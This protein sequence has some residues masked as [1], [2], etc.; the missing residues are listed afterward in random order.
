MKGRI[1]ERNR[2]FVAF[3]MALLMIVSVIDLPV[4]SLK[5]EAAGEKV[6]LRGD[7]SKGGEGNHVEFKLVENPGED[8]YTIE[9]F[10]EG[11]PYDMYFSCNG[12]NAPY[13]PYQGKISKVVIHDGVTRVSENMFEYMGITE[14]TI[15]KDVTEIGAFAFYGNILTKINIP[16]NNS[17]KY[18]GEDAFGGSYDDNSKFPIKDLPR[19][20]ILAEISAFPYIDYMDFPKYEKA[21][22][23]DWEY[24]EGGFKIA[25][26]ILWDVNIGECGLNGDTMNIPEGVTNI[27]NLAPSDAGNIKK[28]HFP[29][30]TKKI[31]SEAFGNFNGLEEMT[32]DPEADIIDVGV[33]VFDETDLWDYTGTEDFMLGNVLLK[34]NMDHANTD[35]ITIASN[36]RTVASNA[37]F[38]GH[39]SVDFNNVQNVSSWLC[40]YDISGEWQFES[41]NM[42][43]VKYI[44][45][46]AF[47][48][49]KKLTSV[50]LSEKLERIS[51]AAFKNNSALE[52][53]TIPDSVKYIETYAFNNCGLKTVGI[54]S[55]S[56]L[57]YI[58]EGAFADNDALEEI[59]LPKSL[60]TLMSSAF[61][62][63][64]LK[65]INIE[66]TENLNCI[67]DDIF[68]D[69]VFADNNTKNGVLYLGDVAI[70]D[71]NT[72][73]GNI[74]IKEGTRVVVA[75]NRR[76]ADK[77]FGINFGQKELTFPTS[78]EYIFGNIV[79]VYYATC[80]E[81]I[82]LPCSLKSFSTSIN[83]DINSDSEIEIV[84]TDEVAEM[85]KFD[86]NI[87]RSSQVAT[88]TYK[89]P[90][91]AWNDDFTK[92]SVKKV[93]AACNRELEYPC[94]LTSKLKSKA[95][96]TSDGVTTVTATCKEFNISESKDV[97]GLKKI[98]TVSVSKDKVA[99]TGKNLKPS[100]VVCDTD[101]KAISSANYDVKYKNNK[102][103]G[104][105][106]A[107]VTFKGDYE[108]SK[109]VNFT[110][111]PKKPTLGKVTIGSKK[112]TVNIK[113][114]SKDMNGYEVQLSLKKDFKKVAK[115]AT[116]K[117]Y[118]NTQKVF[119]GLKAKTGYYVRIRTFKKVKGKNYYS[120]WTVSK[121][122]YKTKK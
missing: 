77:A 40:H 38:Y 98:K 36:V 111:I 7:I 23:N 41:V 16:K 63:G 9:V 34:E 17:L 67:G 119:S 50:T 107:T 78:V 91:F 85:V 35:N 18:I 87:K 65:K 39:E 6:V 97:V 49:C 24:D 51:G 114:A 32:V 52:S 95:S 96:L 90:F 73:E 56:K 79:P 64:N 11:E 88:H 15:G 84:C 46:D 13:V 82:T 81:K 1:R 75:Y 3:I 29:K 94:I 76:I 70:I 31:A 27:S 110:I 37:L 115:K 22:D 59:T 93:C 100:I 89:A 2:K 122:A 108:G 5:A 28:L 109:T 112:L 105:A 86:E 66:S 54:S 53:I 62:S 102:N 118:T 48:D 33:N 26:G 92:C 58:G 69:T 116:L 68:A 101:G 14:L 8:T 72:Q 71:Y 12:T 43:N 106:S 103:I 42:K 117:K 121:K 30:T 44:G 74:S 19:L 4:M 120:D 25:A 80:L 60:D 45:N 83:Y 99:Y 47:R 21:G 10:G 20:N 55:D 104:K 61:S 113:K 57:Q